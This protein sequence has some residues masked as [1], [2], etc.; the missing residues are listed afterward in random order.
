MRDRSTVTVASED[1][2][3]GAKWPNKTEM[4]WVGRGQGFSR[5]QSSSTF[6][7]RQ[8]MPDTRAGQRNSLHPQVQKRLKIHEPQCL[9][10]PQPICH[11]DQLGIASS[12]PHSLFLLFW[13][14]TVTP[15]EDTSGVS[16]RAQ[17]SGLEQVCLS[18]GRE[19]ASSQRA[20][21]PDVQWVRGEGDTWAHD[22]PDL[23]H[24][25]V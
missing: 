24:G 22:L 20:S 12:Q 23:Q 10:T 18:G 7:V 15:S 5:R 14:F 16:N 3:C 19:H 21:H 4:L 9:L 25:L 1:P 8:G 2:H 13:G 17:R 11:R 6:R